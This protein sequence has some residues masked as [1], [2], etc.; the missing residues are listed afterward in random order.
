MEMLEL[1][2]INPIMLDNI[3]YLYF[4]IQLPYL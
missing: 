1:Q 3:S 2:G 4:K